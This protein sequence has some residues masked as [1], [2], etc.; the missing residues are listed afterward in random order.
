[1]YNWYA[2][3]EKGKLKQR[4]CSVIFYV[5]CAKINDINHIRNERT[6]K[7]T[8]QNNV[9]IL[10]RAQSKV[11]WCTY[12]LR[13]SCVAS[14]ILPCHSIW[15]TLNSGSARFGSFSVYIM[16]LMVFFLHSLAS[17][18]VA[19]ILR[20]KLKDPHTHTF[21]MCTPSDFLLVWLKVRNRFL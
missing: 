15:H 21:L 18:F 12:L 17:H 3:D 1:M 16:L 19:L 11:K 2:V 4:K 14:F 9:F 7:K 13:F 10:T 8:Q 6:K 20:P 5:I